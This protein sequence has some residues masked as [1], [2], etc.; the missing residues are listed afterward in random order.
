MQSQPSISGA[1]RERNRLIIFTDTA[2]IR[3]MISGYRLNM[4]ALVLR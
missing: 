1:N 3:M 4:T 2:A